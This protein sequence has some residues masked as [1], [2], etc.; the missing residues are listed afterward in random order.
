[1]LAAQT[2]NRFSVVYTNGDAPSSTGQ[3]LTAGSAN[4]KGLW[5]QIASSANIAYD[6]YSLSMMANNGFV[7]AGIRDI[8]VDIGI[9]LAGGTSYTVA[10]ADMVCGNAQYGARGGKPFTFPLFIPAGASVGARMQCSTASYSMEVLA[11]FLGQPSH[12]E[13]VRAGNYSET[14]GTITN[15]RGVSLTPGSSDAEGTWTSLGTT[16]RP[17]WWWQI[18]T[19]ISNAAKSGL[20]YSY[21][22]GWGDGTNITPIVTNYQTRALTD[23]SEQSFYISAQGDGDVPAGATIYIRA[24]CQGS[25]DATVNAVAIGI[26]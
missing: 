21:D 3:T 19:Q 20:T 11:R 6:V 26:G 7:S 2:P 18:G 16:S 1:M 15:S 10:L 14:I 8:L 17:M 22:L 23:E 5:V 24:S 12:P 25:P 4:V 9:D 13:L